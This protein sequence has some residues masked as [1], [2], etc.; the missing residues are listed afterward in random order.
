MPGG[1][2]FRV[3][4]RA[5]R[6]ARADVGRDGG[7]LERLGEDQH[8]VAASGQPDQAVAQGAAELEDAL[9]HLVE[10]AELGLEQQVDLVA[11]VGEAQRDVVRVDDEP[12]AGTTA[13][14]QL[15]V[16][17]HPAVAERFRID[18]APDPP[19][20]HGR[21]ELVLARLAE[22][23]AGAP[24]G[25]P[26]DDR[27]ELLAGRRRLVAVVGAADQAGAL[28]LVEALGQDGPRHPGQ[29]AGDLVEP[30][31]ADEQVAHDEQRPAV[32][33]DLEGPG[34]RAVLPVP[35]HEPIIAQPVQFRN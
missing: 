6:P 18:T 22:R 29:P 31:R 35:R 33:Q 28:E 32:T 14:G 17:D 30:A 12:E 27:P 15:D 4:A 20:Q 11:G 2:G 16:Q 13:L 21:V 7:E 10:R 24:L 3:T 1:S 25:Q 23:P 19:H 26:E 8:Q 9:P 5:Q 34:D